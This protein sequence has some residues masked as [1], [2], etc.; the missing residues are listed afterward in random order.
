MRR[1]RDTTF[2]IIHTTMGL[3]LTD[4]LVAVNAGLG[5]P[6]SAACMAF[7]MTVNSSLTSET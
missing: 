1:R 2:S 7:V 4:V 5:L 6:L 3:M